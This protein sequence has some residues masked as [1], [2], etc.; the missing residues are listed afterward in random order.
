MD[1]TWTL[2]KK[3]QETQRW[4]ERKIVKRVYGS[5]KENDEWRIKNNQKIDELLKYEDIV[6]FQNAQRI[7]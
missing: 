4:F 1:E 2:T 3:E 7:Q 6:K 5:V